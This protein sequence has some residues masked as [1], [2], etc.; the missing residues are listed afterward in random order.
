MTKHS[1]MIGQVFNRLTVISY[2]GVDKGRRILW[3]CRCSC[4]NDKDI[5]VNGTS[6][7][8]GHTQSCGCLKKEAGSAR[9]IDITGQK[10]GRLTVISHNGSN[11]DR[12]SLWL[13][14][15]DCGEE[16]TV[17]GKELRNGSVQS[18]GCLSREISSKNGKLNKKYSTYD[19][20]GSY[21]IGYTKK[22][23]PFYFDLEDFDK[24]KDICWRY[25]TDDYIAS[26]K[27]LMHRLIMDCPKDM[28][29][30]HIYRVHHDNR[31]S[32]LRIVTS[33]Q[34]NM[35]A[36]TRSDNISG[37]KGVYF[38]NDSMKWASNIKA[39]GKCWCKEFIKKEDAVAYRKLLEIKYHG[40]YALKKN[41][42]TTI[43]Q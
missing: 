16:V 23:E 38:H 17:T 21:G 26:D 33:S 37:V 20:S 18:C 40:E 34:N 5:I 15:C 10:F 24:I 2:Y 1:D 39:G 29:V 32:E 30:D 27:V 41:P 28:E 3:L 12:R 43:K 36:K 19:L 7:R 13:C 11:E 22:N 9:S 25:N 6:L 31:K 35:N 14:K 8:N 4:D 42:E